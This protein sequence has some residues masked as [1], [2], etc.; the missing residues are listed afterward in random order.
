[1]GVHLVNILAENA[2][3]SVFV[4][5]RKKRTS[6]KANVAY[7]TGDAHDSGFLNDVLSREKWDAIVDFMVY[8]TDEFKSRAEKL[9][10]SCGQYVFLSSSRVYAKSKTPITENS[11]RLLDVCTDKEFLAT[12]EY[13]LTKARQENVL[14]ENPRKNWTIIRPYITYSE[15]RL[16]L[17]VLEKETWLFTA[18]NAHALVFSRDIARHTTTL[19]YGFD[20]ARGI[21]AIIGKEEAKGE[22]F[23]ITGNTTIHW[24]RVFDIYAET[25]RKNGIEIEEILKETNYRL[26]NERAKYQLIYDRYFDRVFD[27]SKIARFVDVGTFA[28]PEDKLRTCLEDLL[29]TKNFNYVGVQEILSLLKDTGHSL[30]FSKIPSVKQKIKY[31][32]IKL[33]IWK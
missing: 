18:L 32:L 13:A 23:H 25:L 2:D 6:S 28:K 29:R 33:H 1:M 12:D 27:N 14:F 15:N 5:T 19:T 7:I 21:A 10:S 17:G 31:I 26:F 20:V 24:Q 16:Q 8:N 30:P 3:N 22:A 4:T 11:L 9:L